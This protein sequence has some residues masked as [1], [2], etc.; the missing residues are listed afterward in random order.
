MRL[1]AWTD[2]DAQ[3]VP[4]VNAG[5]ESGTLATLLAANAA[6]YPREIAMREREHGIW[7][8]FTWTQY[9]DAALSFAAAVDALGFKADEGLLVIGD[10]RPKLYFGIVGIG[11]LRGLPAPVFS[12][13]P[14]EEIRFFAANSRARFALA[15]DQEQVDKLLEL[16]ADTGGQPEII[17]Y[18]DPRGL[19]GYTQPGLLA[20]DDLIKRGAV[21]LQVEP[22]LRDDLINRA[23]P[24]DAAVLLHSS[25]TT[26][27]PKG[28]V[29]QHRRAI[30]AV[31][32][33][34]A[35]DYFKERDELM[36]YLPM[37][38]VGD[39]VFTLAG[40][41]VLRF[42]VNI[43]ER[44]DT[45]L[46][47]LREVAPMVYFASPRS[48][49]GMLTHVQVGMAESTAFKRRL[50]G[51]FMPLAIS[52]ER[53]RLEGRSSGF[54]RR[55]LRGIGEWLVFAPLRD[56]L[57]LARA[58]R[59]YTAGEAIGEDT[60]LFFRALGLDLK[61]FYGQTENAALTAAQLSSKV[62][63]HTV[64]QPL[65]GVEI[66]IADD[67]EIL[68]RADSVFDGYLG[69]DAATAASMAGGWLHTGDAGYLEP[70]GDLVV[71]GRASEV[72]H[73]QAGERYIPT[74]I[75]NRLKFSSYVK[76]AA[77]IGDGREHLAA[78]VCIDMAAVGHWAEENGVTYTSFA[79]LSQQPRVCDLI[80]GVVRHVNS[81][82]PSALAIKRFVNLPK[83]FDPDDGEV[84]RTRKL[85]RNVIDER[86]AP[87]IEALYGT[88][89][90]IEYETRIT[91]ETG[92]TGLLKRHLLIR[93]V[94]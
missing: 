2:V 58:R 48:W 65:P 86:Y 79:D 19:R 38:W 8:E 90:T 45:V 13:L 82:L 75:E 83:E 15:E 11:M 91:Y 61:Q 64:G 56:H 70:D 40:G 44:Q 21:R 53:D 71:L 66:R 74:Y 47:N 33:A 6:A 76:D 87:V 12:D 94:A 39:F 43:P 69:D 60:F 3:A 93:T 34:A 41:I 85:R 25:G 59:P 29:L 52:M 10:N 51:Y 68:V 7:K 72:V 67:G 4:R 5:L 26:G 24:K 88:R 81:L 16:R 37:A 63:L 17:I 77:I 14:P 49:D 57:G 73:T 55:I 20:W 50:F 42:C 28:I 46:S 9:L 92:A 31:R 36:A 78:L 89:D 62:K 54:G 23:R 35:A 27:K 30:A 32:N 80:A 22:G 84:T 18:D 1:E